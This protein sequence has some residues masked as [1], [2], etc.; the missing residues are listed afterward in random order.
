MIMAHLVLTKRTHGHLLGYRYTHLQC[1]QGFGGCAWL[2]DSTPYNRIWDPAVLPS[3][4]SSTY[5]SFSHNYP[6]QQCILSHT[7]ILTCLIISAGGTVVC[8]VHVGPYMVQLYLWAAA[9]GFFR[10]LSARTCPPSLSMAALEMLVQGKPR[11]TIPLWS[12]ALTLGQHAQH[13][14]TGRSTVW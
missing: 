5:T 7:P 8:Y 4:Y 9:D 12:L 6:S 11:I 1:L 3:S 14:T 10:T 2:F 13:A